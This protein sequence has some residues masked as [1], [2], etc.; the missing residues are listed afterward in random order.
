MAKPV[1]SSWAFLSNRWVTSPYSHG[2]VLCV[3]S[4]MPPVPLLWKC[5]CRRAVAGLLV[6]FALSASATEVP[7]PLV[8]PVS[9][10]FSPVA[11]SVRGLCD[12]WRLAEKFAA[13]HARCDVMVGRGDSML[14]LYHDRTVLVVQTVPMAELR[15]GMTVVFIGDQGRPVAHALLEKTPAGW[16]VRGVGNR[17]ADRTRVRRENLLGVVVRA[18]APAPGGELLGTQ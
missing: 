1:K 9:A 16:R 2:R 13:T 3:D 11:E 6:G 5:F 4:G 17:E 12:A 15:A 8:L 10:E 14:P 18:Y 7:A